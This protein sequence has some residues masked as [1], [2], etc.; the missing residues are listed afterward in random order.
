MNCLAEP[1]STPQ[2]P[3]CFA[4]WRLQLLLPSARTSSAASRWAFRWKS[5]FLTLDT[6]NSS[7]SLPEVSTPTAC[8][9]SQNLRPCANPSNQTSPASSHSANSYPYC[10]PPLRDITNQDLPFPS[11]R[12]LTLAPGQGPPPRQLS[13]LSP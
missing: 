8:S 12:P 11:P 3:A 9:S 13:W 5:R 6:V 2:A 1:T 4:S 10:V 7:D